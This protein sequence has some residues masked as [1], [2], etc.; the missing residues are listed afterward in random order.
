V[1]RDGGVQARADEVSRAGARAFGHVADLT[2]FA[3]TSA[4]AASIAAQHAGGVAAVAAVAGGFA[5]SGPVELSD[6]AVYAKQIA[7][8]LTSAYATARA[9]APFVRAARGAFVFVTSAAVLPGGSVAGLSAYAMAK[10]GLI[11]LVRALAAEE[12]AHGVRVNA[13]APTAIRTAAN[14]ESMGNRADYVEREEFA[15]AIVALCAP[16]LSRVTGQVIHLR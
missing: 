8:N 16:G 10:G 11:Q 15:D 13:V 9:F 1:D 12:R 14:T 4:L 6:P 7:I 2:D 5:S 3:A